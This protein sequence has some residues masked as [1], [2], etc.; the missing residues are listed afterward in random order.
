MLDGLE[1]GRSFLPAPDL[2]TDAATHE[3]AG[4]RDD[5]AQVV[6]QELF[7]RALSPFRAFA[8]PRAQSR[9]RTAGGADQLDQRRQIV[10]FTAVAPASSSFLSSP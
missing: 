1:E 6:H 2:E 3:L 4:D 7:L 5:E 9:G 8:S 10:E